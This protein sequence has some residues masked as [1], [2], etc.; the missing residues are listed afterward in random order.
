MQATRELPGGYVLRSGV[1]IKN[2][3]TIVWLN[4]AGLVLLVFFWWLFATVA[5][6]LRPTE[7]AQIYNLTWRGWDSL[8]AIG[9]TVGLIVVVIVL[10][11]VIHGLGFLW[12]AR[13]RPVFAFKGA[14]AYAGAP[15]C[16]IPRDPYLV[17]G[18]APLVVL[19]LLAV[20]MLAVVPP[21]A[22]FPL[23]L[24]AVIN[25][26]GAVGDIWVAILLLRQPP[27]ALAIDDG[28]EI[29]IYAPAR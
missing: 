20:G 18:L 21:Q 1:S 7:A 5:L 29:R 8:A 15:G 2:R 28:D 13:V 14:Y 19:S 10:H 9:V 17:I 25:A 16:F 23:L 3:A 24:A 26:S 4:V 12:I 27:D 22:I 6:W 11:E